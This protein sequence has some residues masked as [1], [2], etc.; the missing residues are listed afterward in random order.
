MAARTA[1]IIRISGIRCIVARREVSRLPRLGGALDSVG[2]GR[3]PIT[4]LGVHAI[5]F[6]AEVKNE[7]AGLL[8]ARPCCPLNELLGIYFGS[9][10]R[11]LGSQ[12]GRHACFSR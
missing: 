7:L 10:G 5:S 8:P 3:R 12:T 6:S 2:E 4:S 11:L 9:R 1:S